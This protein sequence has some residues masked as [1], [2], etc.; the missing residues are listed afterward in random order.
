MWCRE[1]RQDLD[2][3]IE[4]TRAEEAARVLAKVGDINVSSL[5]GETMLASVARP[6]AKRSRRKKMNLASLGV[7]SRLAVK[8]RRIEQ[9]FPANRSGAPRRRRTPG[10][11]HRARCLIRRQRVRCFYDKNKPVQVI[12]FPVQTL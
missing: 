3:V 5:A 8:H 9:P 4:R 12:P 10:L 7:F 2:N 11:P 1:I 6:T